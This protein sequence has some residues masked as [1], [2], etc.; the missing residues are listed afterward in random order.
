MISQLFVGIWP[1]FQIF[2]ILHTNSLDLKSARSKDINPYDYININ[3]NVILL[4]SGLQY[5][6][7]FRF[8]EQIAF[9]SYPICAREFTLNSLC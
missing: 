8:T 3:F 5:T 4:S 6:F 1:N 9:V 7:S 2:F